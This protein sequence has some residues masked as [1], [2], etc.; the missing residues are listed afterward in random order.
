MRFVQVDAV[1]APRVKAIAK[2]LRLHKEHCDDLKGDVHFAAAAAVAVSSKHE[3]PKEKLKHD[4]RIH[5]AGNRAKH[6]KLYS[7][8]LGK[9]VS[10][11]VCGERSAVTDKQVVESIARI[12]ARLAEMSCGER[13]AVTDKQV[14]EGIDRIEARLAEMSSMIERLMCQPDKVE[15]R[16]PEQKRT[17][18]SP[19]F[20]ES[21]D[22]EVRWQPP[23]AKCAALEAPVR[24][25]ETRAVECGPVG[26]KAEVSV[27]KRVTFAA[28]CDRPPVHTPAASQGC[29]SSRS[30]GPWA[31]AFVF[32]PDHGTSSKKPILLH[33]G[34]SLIPIDPDEFEDPWDD[35]LSDW[36]ED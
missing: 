31:D 10:D 19:P 26:L 27:S 21:C 28:D 5:R 8:V 18:V 15:V 13:S 3:Q 32:P 25:E 11:V 16:V 36:D 2:S 1:L 30:P 17:D 20:V 9:E 7:D 4:L 24:N 12:E 23:L 33:D 6:D 14:E 22:L 29:A 34:E 35:R